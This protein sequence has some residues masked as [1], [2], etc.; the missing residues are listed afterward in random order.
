MIWKR[1]CYGKRISALAVLTAALS[2]AGILTACGLEEEPEKERKDVVDQMNQQGQSIEDGD[3]REEEQPDAGEQD[4]DSESESE[5]SSR[6]DLDQIKEQF[7]ENCIAEQTFEVELSEY[8]EPVWFVPRSP[9]QTGQ[10]LEIEIIQNG[11]VLTELDVYLPDALA[12]ENFTSLDAVSFYDMDFDNCTDIVLIETYGNSSFAAVY[13]GVGDAGTD[14]PRYFVLQ[15]PL[16]KALSEQVNPLTITEIRNFISGG[17]RNGEFDSYQEAYVAM[18]RLC[19]MEAEEQFYD[20]AYD[21]I[22]VDEDDIPELVACHQGYSVGLYTYWDGTIYTLMN[23]WGYGAMGN[24]GYAYV[25]RRNNVVNDNNDYAGAILYTTYMAVSN[26]QSLDVV[27]CIETYN[28]DDV[29]KN[30]Y[31]DEDELDSMGVY[32]VSYID[33]VEISAEE[34]ASYRV[35]DYEFIE[36]SMTLAE[37]LAALSN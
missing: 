29:N 30:G 7:G 8:P 17:K 1:S 15:K 35:G 10:G 19:D 33:G 18:A 31:P 32:G 28:F 2:V 3:Y 24:A 11:E 26:H 37:L 36:G 9:A 4:A 6:E 21:L 14:D 25:P 5:E 22:Y 20:M 16:S 13:Y 27:A 12:G 34:A 23:D